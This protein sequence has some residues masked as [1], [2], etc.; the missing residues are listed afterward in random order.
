MTPYNSEDEMRS[1]RELY[2]KAG[3]GE[4]WVVAEDGRVRFFAA[5]AEEELE[6]SGLVPEFPEQL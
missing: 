3:A 4:V 6:R 1:K 2:L 5:A